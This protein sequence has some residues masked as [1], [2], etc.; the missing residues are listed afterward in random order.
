MELPLPAASTSWPNKTDFSGFLHKRGHVNT[1]F[2]RRFFV[3]RAARLTYYEDEAAAHRGRSKGSVTVSRVR[4]L[5]PGD[6][7]PLVT[8]DGL[9]PTHLPFAFRFETAERFTAL[10]ARPGGRQKLAPNGE[11]EFAR[12]ARRRCAPRTL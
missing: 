5:R 7:E 6:A 9:P 10:A 2:K 1:A 4:H 8:D 11:A 3:L 12:A